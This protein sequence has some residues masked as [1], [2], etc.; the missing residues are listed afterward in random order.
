MAAADEAVRMILA[1]RW[2]ALATVDEDGAPAGSMVAYAPEGGAA[3][4]LLFLSGLA[5]HTRHLLASGRAA[6]V[7]SDPDPG[8]DDPQT[9]SRVAATGL[10]RPVSY[11][12]LTLPTN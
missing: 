6:V 1:N 7:V 4:L 2:A 10:V 12:H 8:E 11:T 9:L 5:P 3:S